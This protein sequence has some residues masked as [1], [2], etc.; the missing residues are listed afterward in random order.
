MD[1]NE[2]LVITVGGN[3]SVMN[4]RDQVLA[5][6]WHHDLVSFQDMR[7]MNDIIPYDAPLEDVMGWI[8]GELQIAPRKLEQATQGT[9]VHMSAYEIDEKRQNWSKYV[10]GGGNIA[11]FWLTKGQDVIAEA[12][13]D[14][15]GFRGFGTGASVW[16]NTGLA[17]VFITSESEAAEERD[18]ERVRDKARDFI[19]KSQA[20][21]WINDM[22]ADKLMSITDNYGSLLFGDSYGDLYDEITSYMD[23]VPSTDWTWE[24]IVDHASL[25]NDLRRRGKLVDSP[26][27][28]GP[29]GQS[30]AYGEGSLSIEEINRTEAYLQGPNAP[31]GSYQAYLTAHGETP[32]MTNEEIADKLAQMESPYLAYQSA[33]G[34]TFSTITDPSTGKAFSPAQWKAILNPQDEADFQLR[35][36]YLVEKQES[37]ILPKVQETL[38][39]LV[40]KENWE[41]RIPASDL[42]VRSPIPTAP[43]EVPA[44]EYRVGDGVANWQTM[45]PRARDMRLK[46]MH[47]Q[48]L[49]TDEAYNL[50]NAN[51]TDFLGASIWES[52]NAYAFVTQTDPLHALVRIGEENRIVAAMT[53]SGGGYGRS[54]PTYSVPASLREIPDYEAIAQESKQLFSNR[55]G[56]DMEDWELGII[57]DEL[58][59]AYKMQQKEKIE[60]HRAA[61]EDAVSGG[62]VD[63]ESVEVTNPAY[64]VDYYI[65]DKYEAELDRQERVGERSM[66]RGLLMDS[67]T[68]GR[69][70]I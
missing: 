70:M 35:T 63:V 7:A 33:F 9:N 1:E 59:R 62:T 40:Y 14:V 43:W 45:T 39:K 50:M 52:A 44:I 20:N 8:S 21:G 34:L 24:T 61:W 36:T 47:D 53:T 57:S 51:G 41:P 27:V 18:R 37:G 58:G 49:L 26:D 38:D 48:G 68:T 32:G 29:N 5:I 30:Y 64:E 4:D 15:T 66:N 2:E 60:A 31:E 65:E 54:A 3:A 13:Q 55:M 6:L 19:L 25:I 10:E 42:A 46:V 11:E 17:G 56:R 22:L 16:D 12:V 28:M 67:L 69:R 23:D